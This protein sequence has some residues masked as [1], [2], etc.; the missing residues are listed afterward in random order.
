MAHSSSVVILLLA[1]LVVSAIAQSP[2]LSP[3]ASSPS[4]ATVK[5]PPSPS[6]ATTP[7]SIS[8]T[9]SE[10]PAPAQNGAVSN[11]FALAGS[12]AVVAFAGFLVM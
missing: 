3:H 8:G 12:V 11:S 6:P 4:P 10:A 9:P 7:S 5:S 2:A 1:M